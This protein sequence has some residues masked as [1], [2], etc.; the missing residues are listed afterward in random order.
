MAEKN[1]GGDK[2]APPS[3]ADVLKGNYRDMLNVSQGYETMA[4]RMLHT[5][6]LGVEKG[7]GIDYTKADESNFEILAKNQGK[8]AEMTYGVIEDVTK[9]YMQVGGAAAAAGAAMLRRV[10]GID[11]AEISTG[12]RTQL[13]S[14]NL[15]AAG[16]I[17]E[18]TVGRASQQMTNVIY[19]ELESH[20]KAQ[21]KN[22]PEDLARRD[23]RKIQ[24]D[25]RA[26]I[27]KMFGKSGLEDKVNKP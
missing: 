14:G 24:E 27:E 25:R 9:K 18:N 3:R 19:G 13:E 20:Y 7:L 8:I 1:K 11:E 12:I 15:N 2:P 5:S 10:M 21:G 6:L 22:E 23:L 26:R 16:A 4:Q 17:G